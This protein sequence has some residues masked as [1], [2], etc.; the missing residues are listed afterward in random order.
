M[1]NITIT[2]SRFDDDGNYVGP[3][4]LLVGHHGN[5]E[6]EPN[7]GWV[8]VPG[9]SVLGSLFVGANTHI[10]CRS[11]IQCG[12]YLKTEGYLESKTYL[13]VGSGIQAALGLVAG[14]HLNAGLGI[15]SGREIKAG[16]GI[17]AGR[18][19][20]SG[21]GI[22]SG[23]NIYAGKGIQSQ[24]TI[25]CRGAISSGERIFAGLCWW[26]SPT[27][28]DKQIICKKHIRGEIA[29]GELVV[30]NNVTLDTSLWLI[31]EAETVNGPDAEIDC[32]ASGGGHEVLVD[33]VIYS[34]QRQ[35]QKTTKGIVA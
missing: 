11:H 9:I 2:S 32:M 26:K 27:T 10:R 3:S 33:G 5:I 1:R 30:T 18:A 22:F 8:N 16:T 31:R 13:K 12:E 20:Q 7:I 4:D 14:T 24:L 25:A 19:I 6:I 34:P 35:S 17:R 29:Y 21:L 28:E 23:G 15:F